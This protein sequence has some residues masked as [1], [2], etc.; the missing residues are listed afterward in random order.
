MYKTPHAKRPPGSRADA[1]KAP[2]DKL[3]QNP[4][5]VARALNAYIPEANARKYAAAR[6]VTN[7]IFR[8]WY[9]TV[10]IDGLHHLEALSGQDIRT[11]RPP[12]SALLA[13]THTNGFRDI[14]STDEIARRAGVSAVRFVAKL[15]LAVIP[16]AGPLM[17]DM[18]IVPIYRARRDGQ[19]FGSAI[20]AATASGLLEQ[21]PDKLF[22][23]RLAQLLQKPQKP[24]YGVMYPEGTRFGDRSRENPVAKLEPGI[25]MAARRNEVPIVPMALIHGDGVLSVVVQPPIESPVFCG[26]QRMVDTQRELEASMR[27]AVDR[28]YDMQDMYADLA[29][30]PT[31]AGFTEA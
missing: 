16:V 23:Q 2:Y 1:F 8:R 22:E 14:I 12:R 28:A 6:Q 11:D 3:L 21:P 10:L 27:D 7:R 9:P 24:Q 18:G 17:Q 13:P 4:K 26:P 19:K 29:K 25:V 31:D 30:V 20:A 5:R 15:E